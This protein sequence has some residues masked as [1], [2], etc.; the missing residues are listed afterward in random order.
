MATIITGRDVSFT[1]NGANYDAQATSAVLT[2]VV[3]RQAYE[4]LDGTVYKTINRTAT[5][6]IELLSDWGAASS[7]CEALWGEADNYV[8]SIMTV[9]LTSVTGTTFT[10]EIFP[11]YPIVGGTAPDAQ[12]TTFSFTVKQGSVTEAF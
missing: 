9:V 2:K 8:D 7:L 3:D 6:D 10:F 12:T 11:E 4:T 1:I 5:F